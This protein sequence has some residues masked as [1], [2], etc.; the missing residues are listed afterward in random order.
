MA[1]NKK[2]KKIEIKVLDTVELTKRGGRNTINP[3]S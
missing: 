1:D 3:E 2:P